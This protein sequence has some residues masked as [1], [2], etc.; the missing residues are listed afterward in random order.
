MTIICITKL[1]YIYKKTIK[2]QWVQSNMKNQYGLNPKH[3][4]A[5]G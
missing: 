2:E 5:Y 1:I 4:K 3:H